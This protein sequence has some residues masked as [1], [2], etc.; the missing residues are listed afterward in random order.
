MEKIENWTKKKIDK[1]D[2]IESRTKMKNWIKL[3]KIEKMDKIENWTKS[4]HWTKL[5]IGQN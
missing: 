3:D 5:E 1:L 2:K 4:K